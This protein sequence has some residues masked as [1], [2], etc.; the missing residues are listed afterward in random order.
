MRKDKFTNIKITNHLFKLRP[1]GLPRHAID[2]YLD[3]ADISQYG[4]KPFI[5][6]SGRPF[7]RNASIR[8]CIRRYFKKVARAK[9]KKLIRFEYLQPQ[10]L[11]EDDLPY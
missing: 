3:N 2:R 9:A 7:S 1:Y 11:S 8:N 5:G 6:G 4:V 10:P